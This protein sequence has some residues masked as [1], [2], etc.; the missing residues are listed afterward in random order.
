LGLGLLQLGRFGDADA[1]LECANERDPSDALVWGCLAL[2]SLQDMLATH[3]T[4]N[5]YRMECA[6]ACVREAVGLGLDDVGLLFALA[7]AY[8]RCNR[9]KEEAAALRRA[10]ELRQ[11]LDARAALQGPGGAAAAAAASGLPSA[12]QMSNALGDSLRAQGY[13]LHALDIYQ[14]VFEACLEKQE[15]ELGAWQGDEGD[16]EAQEAEERATLGAQGFEPQE[17]EE[18][19]KSERYGGSTVRSERTAAKGGGKGVASQGE[20]AAASRADSLRPTALAL[21]PPS[22]ALVAVVLE[23]NRAALGMESLLAKLG[24]TAELKQLRYTAKLIN[25]R[26]KVAEARAMQGTVAQ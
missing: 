11:A 15:V 13:P 1:A 3:A 2:C 18:E 14:G 5:G 20:S 9:H 12:E 25:S 6:A 21:R 24:R 16:E 26:L 4:G 17:D 23:L 8:G 10:L 22:A 19:N 7:Q